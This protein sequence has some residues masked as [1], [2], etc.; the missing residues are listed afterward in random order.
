LLRCT[1]AESF[2]G[3]KRKVPPGDHRHPHGPRLSDDSMKRDT[4]PKNVM[5][6]DDGMKKN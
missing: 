5:K 2:R 1:L 3:K 4:M 6:K